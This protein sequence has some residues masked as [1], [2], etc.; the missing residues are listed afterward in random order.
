MAAISRLQQIR[1]LKTAIRLKKYTANLTQKSLAAS[2]K[3]SFLSLKNG[4]LKTT[5]KRIYF[6]VCDLRSQG[7]G[8]MTQSRLSSFIKTRKTTAGVQDDARDRE[9]GDSSVETP[10]EG[11]LYCCVRAKCHGWIYF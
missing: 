2:Q 3:I 1:K 10:T 5:V 8:K 4:Q 11:K 9:F 6:Y 7:G